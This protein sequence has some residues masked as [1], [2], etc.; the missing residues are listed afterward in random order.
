M[1]YDFSARRLNLFISKIA[2]DKETGCWNWTA[3]VAP[4]GYGQFCA[5]GKLAYA[6]RYIAEYL[7]R[8][9]PRTLD[10]DHVCRNRA[11]CNPAHLEIVTRKTNLLRGET[12]PAFKASQTHCSRGHLLAGANVYQTPS[13]RTRQCRTCRRNLSA[14]WANENRERRRE[15]D[16]LAYHRNKEQN[17]EAK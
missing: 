5:G 4:N 11:C 10:V 13:T 8:N 6:H 3:Y 2:E 16:R 12:I 14:V 7:N 1:G 9:I 17:H 15:I